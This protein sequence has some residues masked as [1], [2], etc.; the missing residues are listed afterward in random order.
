[1]EIV[2]QYTNKEFGRFQVKAIKLKKSTLTPKGPI[3]ENLAIK[4]LD[5]KSTL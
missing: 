4:T 2:N 5:A 3:Y 1:M